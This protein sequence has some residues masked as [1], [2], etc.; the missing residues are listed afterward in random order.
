M[1]LPVKPHHIPP[2]LAA[3]T[4]ILASGLRKLKAGEETEK[5]L[6]GMAS[7]A[8]PFLADI[9]PHRFTRLLATAEVGL[10][11]A[12]LFPFVPSA[13]AGAGLT[14]FSSGLVGLYLRTPGT[15]HKGSPLPT[16]EGVPLAKDVWLL[17]IG[18]GLLSDRH[19]WARPC[20]RA[21]RK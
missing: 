15:H 16:E 20:L 7:G 1:Y 2:R 10:G 13:A 3:G 12:L 17:G 9:A 6:H 21:R 14:A 4:F 8:Y 11:T 19:A 5:G 18:L